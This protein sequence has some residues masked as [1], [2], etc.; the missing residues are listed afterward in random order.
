MEKI[1][2]F[3]LI[4]I[5]LSS[6]KTSSSTNTYKELVCDDHSMFKS[7]RCDVSVE[8]FKTVYKTSNSNFSLKSKSKDIIKY[9]IL[10][11]P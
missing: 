10:Q 4:I 2:L 3:F 5:Y 9:I 6:N 11:F 8:Y 1:I 7:T